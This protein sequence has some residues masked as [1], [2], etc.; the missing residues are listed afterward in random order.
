M[1]DYVKFP[2]WCVLVGG[3]E[4]FSHILGIIWNN[5]PNKLSYFSGGLKPPTIRFWCL[6]WPIIM[7]YMDS[8]GM[9]IFRSVRLPV[10]PMNFGTLT[11]EY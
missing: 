2:T 4:H 5:N 6:H 1:P 10:S 8:Q 11:G 7:A 3:L 9:M